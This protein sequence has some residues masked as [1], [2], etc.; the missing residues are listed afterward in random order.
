MDF[1]DNCKFE[2]IYLIKCILK[3]LKLNLYTEFNDVQ[4]TF[5]IAVLYN[6]L[7]MQNLLFLGLAYVFVAVGI[8]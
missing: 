4:P 7:T 3:I 2:L 1:Y 6:V 8:N 5:R